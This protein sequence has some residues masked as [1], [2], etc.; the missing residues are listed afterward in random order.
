MKAVLQT[1]DKAGD[2][3]RNKTQQEPEGDSS[4]VEEVIVKQCA[5][6]WEQLWAMGTQR[7][8]G[9]GEQQ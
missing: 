9:S 8:A 4:L 7:R 2:M 3:E 1:R 5:K 6:C